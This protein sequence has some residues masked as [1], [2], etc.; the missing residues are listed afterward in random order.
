MAT[1][2]Q[3][4]TLRPLPIVGGVRRYELIEDLIHKG[5]V[6]AAGFITDGASVPRPFWS[7]FPHDGGT[8]PAALIHDWDYLHTNGTRKG[9]DKRFLANMKRCGLAWIHRHIIYRAVR[10]GGG[11]SWRRYRRTEL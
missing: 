10:L 4:P 2:P 9:A 5:G 11:T 3:L 7:I 6:V 8:L 1:F